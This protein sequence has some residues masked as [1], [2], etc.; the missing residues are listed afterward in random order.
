MLALRVPQ[1]Q[2]N[3]HYKTVA[4]TEGRTKCHGSNKKRG[5]DSSRDRAERPSK[6]DILIDLRGIS[7]ATKVGPWRQSLESELEESKHRVGRNL[8]YCKRAKCQ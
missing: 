4:I 3:N 6:R 2:R 1:S 8:D 7:R 5:L